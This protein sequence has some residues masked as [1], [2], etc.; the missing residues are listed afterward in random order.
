MRIRSMMAFKLSL[1]ASTLVGS[2]LIWYWRTKPPTLATSATPSTE[3]S[4]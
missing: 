4:Q 3:A 1:Y 2:R